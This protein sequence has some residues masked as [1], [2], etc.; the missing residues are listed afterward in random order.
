MNEPVIYI[1]VKETARRYGVSVSF[2]AKM[3]MKNQG[4]PFYKLGARVLYNPEEVSAWVNSRR[5][6]TMGGV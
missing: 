4:P 6:V 3:R 1:D 5:A 2:L